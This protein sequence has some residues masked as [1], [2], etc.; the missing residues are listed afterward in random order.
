MPQDP[1]PDRVLER[2]AVQD[3]ARL[4]LTWAGRLS[5]SSDLGRDLEVKAV[6][7]LLRLEDQGR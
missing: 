4:M 1:R 6:E 2:E 7:A 3:V 5:P